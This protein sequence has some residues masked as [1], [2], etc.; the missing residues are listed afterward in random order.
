VQVKPT[1]QENSTQP[2]MYP[3][4]QD[5]NQALPEFTQPSLAQV[6]DSFSHCR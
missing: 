5:L 6:A 1:M 3:P 4:K 2:R